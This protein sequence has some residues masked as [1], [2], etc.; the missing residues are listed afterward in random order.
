MTR[1]F[2]RKQTT[3][4]ASFVAG[5]V[6]ACL[7]GVA[8]SSSQQTASPALGIAAGAGEI[9]GQDLFGAYDVVADW[10]K[11]LATLPGHAGWT[12]GAGQSIFAESPDRIFVLQRG[13]LPEVDR[14]EVRRLAP[15]ITFPI[16]RLPVRDTTVAS[17]PTNGA[18]GVVVADALKTWQA[19]G[20]QLGV[21]A[22]W[23]HCI[24]VLN[25]QG[26]VTDSWT[27]WDSLLQLPHY[28]AINP[29]DAEKHVWIVDDHKHV[30]HKFT[31]DGKTKVMTLGA[32]GESGS[33]ERHFN[34][35]TFLDWFPDGSFVVADGYYG[36]RV[37]KFDRDGRYVMSWGEK[38]VSRDDRA[39]GHFNNVHGIA[40]DRQTGRVFVNDRANQ[41]IQVFD[42][43]GRFLDEWR[44]GSAASDIHVIHIMGDGYLWAADRGTNKI[45]KWTL[46][47]RFLY[48]WGT[49]GDFPGGM[50]GVHGMSVDQLG[51]FY[52]AEVG[53][54]GVQK[55]RPRPGANPAFLV[56]RPERRAW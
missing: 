11:P 39:P 53:N 3:T 16:G 43:R 19:R 6:V 31:N 7:A 26:E 56:G 14:P 21:D 23:E 51:N 52:V 5:L 8:L 40:I 45:L 1:H 50:W 36:T 37:V 33:D 22:R 38:S 46:D 49:F 10:P 44:T 4:V 17:L 47:G 35:P 55:F 42:D 2:I 29:Y 27:Q 41:R 34:R 9:G 28:V 30:I 20:Y 24:L 15:S 13:E 25:G 48:S 18:T 32:Y 54:G 12:Y